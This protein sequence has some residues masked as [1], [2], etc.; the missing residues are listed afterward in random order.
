MTNEEA[1]V[2]VIDALESLTIP[3]LALVPIILGLAL[4]A[5]IVLQVAFP[6]RLDYFVAAL[7]QMVT[8][9]LLYCLFSNFVSILRCL[10]RQLR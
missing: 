3:Y 7:F 10:S 5:V 4:V 2:A 6:M 8:M 9:F 1:T